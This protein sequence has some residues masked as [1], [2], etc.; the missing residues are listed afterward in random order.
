[1]GV[2]RSSP[3]T[4]KDTTIGEDSRLIYAASDMQ[5]WRM[6]MEDARITNLTVGTAAVFAVFDGHGGTEVSKFTA[7]HFCEELEFN[8]SFRSGNI[9]QALIE[10][11]LRIDQMLEMPQHLTELYCLSQN[12]DKAEQPDPS[13]RS[14]AGCTAVAA[15]VYGDQ[16]YV[17]NA[18]DSRCVV[19]RDGK[20]L[21]MSE[22][23]KPDLPGEL[24]RI[25]K[26]GGYVEAGRVNSNL[27]LSRSLG[28]LEYK[29]ARNLEPHEQIISGYPEVRTTTIGPNDHFMV[30]ACDGVWDILTSQQCVE[31]VYQRLGRHTPAEIVEQILT[32]CLAPNTNT[33]LGCDNMTCILVVFKKPSS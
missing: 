16:I 17:A 5:G 30:L 22:D 2:Y 9:E 28:D 11:F 20:A 29:R 33:G 26:A 4:E 18:G 31:F 14:L 25:R 12:L 15:V 13:Y 1:M 32:R 27:N 7:R 8:T 10:T 21:E 3:L 23:H 24:A 6:T 19:G